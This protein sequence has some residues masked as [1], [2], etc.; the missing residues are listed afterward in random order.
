MLKYEDMDTI[1]RL[2]HELDQARDGL[3]LLDESSDL[4]ISLSSVHGSA[5]V[6]MNGASGLVRSIRDVL[7]TRCADLEQRMRDMGVEP[8]SS[9]L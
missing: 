1:R 5:Y 6:G 4:N 3:R 9:D 7:V 8:K 2:Q